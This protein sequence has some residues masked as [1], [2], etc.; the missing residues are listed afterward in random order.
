M[1]RKAVKTMALTLGCSIMVTLGSCGGGSQ[2]QQA[3]AP[4]LGVLTVSLGN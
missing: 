3:A 2:Q 1:Y 4:E